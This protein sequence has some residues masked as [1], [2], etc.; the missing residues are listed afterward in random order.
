LILNWKAREGSATYFRE[1]LRDYMKKWVD[2]NKKPDG[3]DYDIY[4]DGLKIYT[5]IDSRM[6]MLKKLFLH[7]IFRKNFYSGKNNKTPICRHLR[8]RNT[9]YF[10]PM[11]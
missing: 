8:Q 11:Q 6:H 1:Y 2:E 3:S 4:K 10:D 5:T 9:A 7:I